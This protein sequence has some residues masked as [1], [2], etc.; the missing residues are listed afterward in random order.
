MNSWDTEKSISAASLS[1]YYIFSKLKFLRSSWMTEFGPLT[2]RVLGKWILSMTY[3]FQII[4]IS[5]SFIK[6][7]QKWMA[8][9]SYTFR[10]RW[11]KKEGRQI[12]VT[13]LF[14]ENIL[15]W[16]D[17]Q[18]LVN[19]D[20]N[21]LHTSNIHTNNTLLVEKPFLE[22]LKDAN[23]YLRKCNSNILLGISYCYFCFL[24]FTFTFIPILICF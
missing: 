11:I 3:V 7:M 22:W 20:I 9:F 23:G 14:N 17:F 6:S 10:W 8:K 19:I 15:R 1:L 24:L 16:T 21:I 5:Y 13:V 4:I 2:S 18:L 12:S